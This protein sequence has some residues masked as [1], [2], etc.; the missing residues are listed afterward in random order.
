M[1][2]EKDIYKTHKNNLE[3]MNIMKVYF[4]NFWN[5]KI[6]KLPKLILLFFKINNFTILMYENK[7]IN[8]LK[9]HNQ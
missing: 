3:W 9:V 7:I 1:E 4:T 6:L 5:L 2:L 8:S